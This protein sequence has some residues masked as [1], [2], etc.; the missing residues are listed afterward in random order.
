MAPMPFAQQRSMSP[1]G[2]CYY[3]HDLPSMSICSRCGRA[4]CM[5]CTKPY[6]ELTFCPECYWA[7][8]PRSP[9]RQMQQM[10]QQQQQVQAQQMRGYYLG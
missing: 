1:M 5:S 6:Q 8:G 9:P 3:H 4:I 2:A 10:S 7:L